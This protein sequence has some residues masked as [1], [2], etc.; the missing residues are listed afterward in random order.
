MVVAFVVGFVIDTEVGV[1]DKADIVVAAVDTVKDKWETSDA[2]AR[3][4][5]T[6]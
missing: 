4:N 5:L 3:A 1:V 2:V 6:S